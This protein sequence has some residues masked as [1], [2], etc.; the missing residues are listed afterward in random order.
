MI[1]PER[2]GDLP[3]ATQPGGGRAESAVQAA[4]PP[5]AYTGFLPPPFPSFVNQSR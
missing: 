4:G 3:K 1:G 5:K 2:S